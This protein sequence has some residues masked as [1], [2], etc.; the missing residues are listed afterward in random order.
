MRNGAGSSL[1]R[2]LLG[3]VGDRRIVGV[4][5]A[6]YSHSTTVFGMAERAIVPYIENDSASAWPTIGAPHRAPQR[7]DPITRQ[8][9]FVPEH[10]QKKC[11]SALDQAIWVL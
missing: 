1:G 8:R 3:F 6:T 2:E 10:S 7:S 11:V 5:T 9:G 4:D